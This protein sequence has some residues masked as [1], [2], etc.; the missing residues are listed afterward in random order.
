MNI[1]KAL[2]IVTCLMTST[3]SFADDTKIYD[4]RC[5]QTTNPQTLKP[6]QLE[7]RIYAKKDRWTSEYS[8]WAFAK[9]RY[10]KDHKDIDVKFNDTKEVQG[11]DGRPSHVRHYFTEI[12]QGKVNGRYTFDSQGANVW[13]LK[14]YA[15][16]SKTPL[17]FEEAPNLLD[18]NAD[19]CF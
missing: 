2:T 18:S 11:V 12:Y 13:G 9:V 19:S 1:L 15:K 10:G 8:D 5:W 14:Y 6:I 16:N 3:F 17:S 7:F 4:V